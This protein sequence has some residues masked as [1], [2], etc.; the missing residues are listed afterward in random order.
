MPNQKRREVFTLVVVFAGVV[1][2]SALIVY[3]V[4]GGR[5]ATPETVRQ[6]PTP[7]GVLAPPD[8]RH[9]ATPALTDSGGS[10]VDQLFGTQHP[11]GQATG[12][13]WPETMGR[14]SLRLLLA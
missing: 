12:G 8:A 5:R 6:G 2:L 7:D 11:E 3:F 9:S 4:G 14:L 10:F 1:F 13:T